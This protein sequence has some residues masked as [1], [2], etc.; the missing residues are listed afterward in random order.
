M[1]HGINA[2]ASDFDGAKKWIEAAHPGTF[3][4]ALPVFQGIPASWANLGYQLATIAKDIDALIAQNQALFSGGYHLVCHSQGGLLCRCLTE[5]MNNH[6]VHTL[7]SMAGP[8]MGVY[9]RAYFKFFGKL[10]N[11]TLS[12]IYILAYGIIEQST[13]SVANMWDDPM[14]H[15]EY[16]SS[17]YFLPELNG[18][19]GD[20][21]KYKANFLRLSK[22]VFLVGAQADGVTY[23]GGIGPWQ[24]GAWGHYAPGSESKIQ[25]MEQQPLYT[26]DTFGLRT[27]NETG[28]LLVQT[29]AGV[30]HSGWID[31][32]ATFAQ[33]V[34]PHLV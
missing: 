32:E 5:T 14:H 12:D 21:S 11:F 20:P 17:N 29:P 28:R 6:S 25:P 16:L 4:Y 3:T 7:V 1:L 10:A 23:D 15:S 19:R 22:A 30:P 13:L 26:G 33:Y 18:V 31:D 9:D 24:S 2:H 27:L 34:L 8:Q